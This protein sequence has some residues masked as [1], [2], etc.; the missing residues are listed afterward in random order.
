MIWRSR[1]AHHPG[2]SSASRSPLFPQPRRPGAPHLRACDRAPASRPLQSSPDSAS[3]GSQ[4]LKG[5]RG[6]GGRGLRWRLRPG[7]QCDASL[8]RGG[9][10]GRTKHREHTKLMLGTVS[11]PWRCHEDSVFLPHPRGLCWP[12]GTRGRLS[13]WSSVWFRCSPSTR[14]ALGHPEGWVL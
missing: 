8:G 10:W 4:G 2:A 7:I 6:R 14:T 3:P 1:L 11:S 9:S 5:R 13:W 12:L